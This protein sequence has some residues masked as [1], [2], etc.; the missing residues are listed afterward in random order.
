LPWYKDIIMPIQ[1][2]GIVPVDLSQLHDVSIS[3]PADGQ[4]LRYN[5]ALT[6]PV[7]QNSYIGVDVGN[8]LTSTPA[9]ITLYY[10]ILTQKTNISLTSTAVAAGTYGSSTQVPIFTVDAKGRITS[11]IN[12]TIAGAGSASVLTTARNISTTGDATWT[13]S[14]DGSANVTNPITLATVNSSPVSVSFRKITANGKGLVTA[15][16]AVVASDITTALAYTPV[17]KAGDTMTG[18]L[19]LSADPTNALGAVTKQ[20]ADAI[21][22]GVQVHSACEAS[23]IAALP[24]CTY[25]NGSS[26]VG[27]TLT[28]TTNAAIGLI[29]GYNVHLNGRI[30]VKNQASQIQN[31]IYV[32][33]DLGSVSTPWILTRAT[34]F[35]GS[36]SYEVGPGDLTYIQEGSTLA[37]TQWVETGLGTISPGDYIIIGTDN[38]VFSQFSGANTLVGGTGI[39]VTANTITNTGV[40]SIVAGTNI[41]ISPVGG[42]GA[43]TINSSGTVPTATTTTNIASGVTGNVPYQ[44]GADTTTFVTNAAGV[45]QALTSGATPT[46]TTTPTLTGT[47]FSGTAASLTAGHV[48]NGVY[49]TDTGTVTNAMLAGSISNSKLAFSVINLGTTTISLGSTLNN[50]LSGLTSVDAATFTGSFVG[51]GASLTSIPNSALVGSGQ[52]TL[53]ASAVALGGTITNISGLTSLTAT[54]AITAGSLNATSTKRVKKSIKNLS[55]KYLAKFKDLQPREYDRKDYVAHEFGFIAEEMA[56]VYPEVVGKDTDGIPSGIDYG[57][58]STILTAKVQEQQ[59]TIEKL[60]NQMAKVMEVLKDLSK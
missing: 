24:T 14:F 36:P 18:L 49:T 30:L 56:L 26:G 45:L 25:N 55:K 9:D 7:W 2:S 54:G 58:L 6:L 1:V 33:T 19:I 51:S 37:G 21:A 28:A 20:Y 3:A 29:D 53:G 16:S 13:V 42:T 40:T 43:V 50:T 17:N 11:A 44:T 60:Q 23:T 12:T 10:D 46:W 34:D 27:A 38:I 5:G 31:G 47:N 22:A 4:Y 57:K 52:I 35:D 48:T 32:V 39:D 41:S 59:V 8:A 15:T